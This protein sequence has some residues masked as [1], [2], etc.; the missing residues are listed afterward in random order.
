MNQELDVVVA[1][2]H[3]QGHIPLKLQGFEAGV[4]V[5]VGLPLIRISADHDTAFNIAGKSTADSSNT[6]KAIRN[7]DNDSKRN[8][9][10]R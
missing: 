2:Y 10:E 1:M 6:M 4:I 9:A 7:G 5:T 3:G 8:I